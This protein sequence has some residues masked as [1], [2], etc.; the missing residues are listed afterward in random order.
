MTSIARREIETKLS[1]KGFRK[2][3]ND[4]RYYHFYYKDKRTEISTKISTGSRYKEYGD[5]L[6]GMVS[7][8]LKLSK[9]QL[10]LLVECS[11]TEDMYIAILKNKKFL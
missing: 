7:R 10:V 11:L 3:E 2:R 6:L 9:E 4:H 5:C 1:Q 8:Q